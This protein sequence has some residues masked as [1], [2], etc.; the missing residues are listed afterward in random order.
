MYMHT[1]A[2]KVVLSSFL[3]Y[4][5]VFLLLSHFSL[6]ESNSVPLNSVPFVMTRYCATLTTESTQNDICLCRQ[7][8]PFCPLS[9]ATEMS[10]LIGQS[11]VV[12]GVVGQHWLTQL[13]CYN[14]C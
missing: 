7:Q 12:V 5:D 6:V 8:C 4:S 9:T 3:K 2:L 14:W 13:E 10:C 1:L 11:L